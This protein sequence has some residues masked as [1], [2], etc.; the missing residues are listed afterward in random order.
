MGEKNKRN[1]VIEP[2]KNLRREKILSLYH[3]GEYLTT[4]VLARYFNVSTHTIRRDLNALER[5]KKLKR[6]HGG[7]TLLSNST[8]II[9]EKFNMANQIL[10]SVFEGCHIYIDSH[11]VADYIVN[12][13]PN[14]SIKLIASEPD[15][16]HLIK[17]KRNVEFFFLGRCFGGVESDYNFLDYI[18]KDIFRYIDIAIVDANYIDSQGFVLCE[19]KYKSTINRLALENA[20][21]R[22]LIRNEISKEK[23]INLIYEVFSINEVEYVLEASS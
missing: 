8:K 21:C 9:K 15:L 22:Y 20:E 23:S 13:L 7:A 2:K 6:Y 5:Q 19:N 18:P 3:D 10:L 11:Y 4:D 17:D 12:L 1:N 14:I 16:Y